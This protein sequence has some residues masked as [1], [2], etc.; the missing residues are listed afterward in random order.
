MLRL[1]LPWRP[2]PLRYNFT[3]GFTAYTKA[4]PDEWE[5]AAVLHY[6]CTPQ[7][8]KQ[9]LMSSYP[10]MD[11]WIR[12]PSADEV[13]TGEG[14]DEAERKLRDAFS[15]LHP[16]VEQNW[17]GDISENSTTFP[18]LDGEQIASV[19]ARIPALA[20][21]RAVSVTY[22]MAV[23]NIEITNRCPLRCV[24]CARTEDMTRAQGDMEFQLFKRIIDEL[25]QCNPSWSASVPV[26]LHGFGESL[27]HPEFDRFIAYSEKHGIRTCLSINPLV[28]TPNVRS[29]LLDAEPSLLYISLD[30]HDNETFEQIRG[31]RNAYDRSEA[32]L[33]AFLRE[34]REKGASS[35]VV[36]S[37]IDFER[38]AASIR[39]SEGYWSELDGVDEFRLK[40]FTTWDGNSDSVNRL[41][42]ISP[43]LEPVRVMA[44]C[45]WPWTA[46]TVL[47]DGDVV[48]CCNDF[49]KRYVLGN[50]QR[51][52]LTSIWNGEPMT[53]LRSELARGLVGNELCRNCKNL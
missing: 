3:P 53:A 42:G 27:I 9:R 44:T 20:A 39:Q 18:L 48:P 21:D 34:K 8:D 45:R 47:W 11:R 24:M 49:D 14:V 23:F 26:R 29:R 19:H 43:S 31:V 6:T 36:V 40:P 32:N 17:V 2:I 13:S 38:N 25:A 16:I 30:G 46:M 1:K 50:V 41:V 51:Q 12:R 52:S 7:F 37:M 28:M 22:P 33:L 5:N 4:L 15:A 10:E 35:R